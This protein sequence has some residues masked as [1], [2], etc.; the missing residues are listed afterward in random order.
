MSN[1]LSQELK[2][3][4]LGAIGDPDSTNEL[5]SVIENDGGGSVTSVALSVPSIF[6]VSGSPITSSGTL[7]AS[8]NTQT[9]NT[10]FAGPSA[11][12]AVAPAF[13]NIVTADVPVLNQNTTGTASNVTGIVAIANGGSGQSTANTALN[14]FLPSQATHAGEFLTTDGVNTSWVAGGSSPTGDPNTLSYFDGAGNLSDN[15]SA[16]FIETSNS[17]AFGIETTS[18]SI[19]SVGNGALAYGS[20]DGASSSIQANNDGALAHGQSINGGTLSSTSFGSSVAGQADGASSSLQSSG[21]GSLTL[22]YVTAAGVINSGGDGSIAIGRTNNSGVISTSNSGSLAMGSAN[23]SSAISAS[24]VGS[25]ACGGADTN[26]STSINASAN[27]S[28]AHGYATNSFAIVSANFGSHA[29]GYTS[30]GN[31]IAN[32]TASFAHGNA[33]SVTADYAAAFGLGHDVQSFASFVVGRYAVPTGTSSSW[34]STEPLLICGNGTG[35]G[36]EAN[37]FQL[38]KDG[39]EI[40]T[41]SRVDKST[42][43]IAAATTLSARTN[44]TV[45]LDTNGVTG[46]IQLPAGEDGLEFRFSIVS[47]GA[48]V[49]TLQP[50]G[51][52]TFDAAVSLSIDAGTGGESIIFKTGTWYRLF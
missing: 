28:I 21:I 12:G 8:L 44:R 18:G 52:N 34:V 49:Y 16:K 15:T 51:G 1:A 2:K 39:R 13:R 45:I 35:I 25:I 50:N 22:G 19:T 32:G 26:N 40:T 11:G 4:L 6:S 33:L 5:I 38:D 46:N 20:A 42:T 29:A 30:I 7:T 24:G 37:A 3:L 31:I 48:A 17:M 36:T 23:D 9:A 43:I 10:F 27:G 41:A 47:G 14:A